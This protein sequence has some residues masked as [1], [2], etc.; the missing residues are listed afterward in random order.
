MGVATLSHDEKD[1]PE[2]VIGL[3]EMLL[4]LKDRKWVVSMNYEVRLLKDGKYLAKQMVEGR[5]ERVKII[6]QDAAETVIDELFS[7][8]IH[9]VDLVKLFRQAGL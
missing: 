2:L 3:R 9:R 4:D 7:D 5:A 6:G 8:M 1:K